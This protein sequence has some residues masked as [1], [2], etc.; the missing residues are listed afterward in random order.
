MGDT[1][2]ITEKGLLP[3]I[4]K[5]MAILINWTIVRLSSDKKQ[6]QIKTTN[7]YIRIELYPRGSEKRA[8]TIL[9]VDKGSGG[10]EDKFSNSA[11][12][13]SKP[14][15]VET[16]PDCSIRELIVFERFPVALNSI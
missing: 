7:D 6:N 9:S 12:A 15:I 1:H 16:H 8:G 10:D 13:P 5:T 14:V 3:E 4:S 2:P 11:E